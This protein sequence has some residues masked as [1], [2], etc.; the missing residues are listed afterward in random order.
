MED[1]V[2]LIIFVGVVVCLAGVAIRK[3]TANSA[4]PDL[5]ESEEFVVDYRPP[6]SAPPRDLSFSTLNVTAEEDENPM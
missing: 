1:G 4:H 3:C 2:I 5:R 6:P